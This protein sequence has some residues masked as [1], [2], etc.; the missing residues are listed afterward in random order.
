MPQAIKTPSLA[1][2]RMRYSQ[3]VKAGPHYYCSGMVALDSKTGQLQG[4]S[5]G[6]ETA[7]ILANL[8][9]LMDD[10]GLCL[11]D[12]VQARIFTTRF[13]C[14]A[15]INQAWEQLFVPERVP[16]ARTSVGVAALPLGASVEIE[17]IFYKE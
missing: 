17:F 16:P 2:P 5:P 1:A 10:L 15:E 9:L 8:H 6:E 14:F 13:D 7:V 11:D 3:V 12:L 4:N